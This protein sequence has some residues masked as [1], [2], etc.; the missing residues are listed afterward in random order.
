M[1]NEVQD[2]MRKRKKKNNKKKG[3]QRSKIV[4]IAAAI[5][6]CTLF[7]YIDLHPTAEQTTKAKAVVEVRQYWIVSVGGVPRLCF[8]RFAPDGTCLG[9][10]IDID[11]V[12]PTIHQVTGAWSH[13]IPMLPW[14]RGRISAIDTLNAHF[15]TDATKLVNDE[16]VRIDSALKAMHDEDDELRYYLRVHNVQDEGYNMI[17]DYRTNLRQ[18]MRIYQQALDTL[19][20]VRQDMRPTL[21]LVSN[22][23]VV[24]NDSDGTTSM[25]PC[26]LLSARKGR[27]RL[28]TQSRKMPSDAKSIW[29][30]APAIDTIAGRV[31]RP[32]EDLTKLPQDGVH[33]YK[34]ADGTYY[35]GDWENG[36]RNGFGF[37]IRGGRLRVGEWKADTYLGERLVYTTQR[38]YGIDISKYQHEIG[39]R[40]YG[41]QWNRLRINHL[42]TI[43]EKRIDGDV[44]FPVSFVY[45]KSTEGTTI[46]NA[47]FTADYAQARRNGIRT[48]AYHFFSI[49]TSGLA[50][51]Q[52]FLRNTRFNKGD[53]PPVLDVEPTNAQINEMGG[54]SVL[55]ANIRTWMKAVEKQVGVRPILYVNQKFVNNHLTLA[56]DIKH[57]YQ[58][59]IARYG[60]Y[61]PDV[62]L[63]IWQLCPDGRVTGIQG[64]VD[65]NVFNGYQNEFDEFLQNATIK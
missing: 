9:I 54:D 4:A 50:Q 12:A 42:G 57:D 17:A 7:I 51:A 31:V 29:L 56:P 6:L 24:H 10:A 47:Y 16:K 58:V 48:G 8:S 65:I 60:E 25:E 18:Q 39:R 63:S 21:H 59:W 14:N 15:D 46:R 2:H 3:K 1:P 36:Q 20:T 22:Y 43:S 55:F 49:R 23:Y 27:L 5:I 45:I 44:D 11:S 52:H 61:K 38:I 35:E 13:R 19:S 28:Q 53:L 37:A 62:R 64:H 41:I 34:S 33:S 26:E 30:R 32:L 40:K